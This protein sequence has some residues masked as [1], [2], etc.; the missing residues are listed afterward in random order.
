MS[1]LQTGTAASVLQWNEIPVE[2]VLPAAIRNYHSRMCASANVCKEEAAQLADEVVQ[3]MQ[4]HLKPMIGEV[5]L[6]VDAFGEQNAIISGHAI[7]GGVWATRID[8]KSTVKLYCLSSGCR[9]QDTALACEGDL[10]L[11]S[12]AHLLG[13][14]VIF[15]LTRMFDRGLRQDPLARWR[16]LGL[17]SQEVF[18]N[19]RCR[20]DPAVGTAFFRAFTDHAAPVTMSDEGAFDPVHSL[21]GLFCKVERGFPIMGRTLDHGNNGADQSGGPAREACGSGTACR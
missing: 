17:I 15:E 12:A 8:L 14:E 5:D 1:L 21:L 18:V 11:A 2:N 16:K 9:L 4:P 3:R 10:L 7:P 20:W 6:H 19:S 13:S